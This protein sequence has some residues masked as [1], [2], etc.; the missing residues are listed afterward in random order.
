MEDD[1]R[2]FDFWDALGG[3]TDPNSL[4]EGDEDEAGVAAGGAAKVQPKLF[5]ISDATGTT[6]FTEIV[7]GDG[8]L[9]KDL[10]HSG[11]VFL[12]YGGGGKL[13]LWIGRGSSL[14]EK[15]QASKHAAE[16]IAQHGLSKGTSVERV[17]EGC[18]TVAF[19][20][21]F[22]KWELPVPKAEKKAIAAKVI[23]VAGLLAAAPRDAEGGGGEAMVD[24]GSGTVVVWVVHDFKLVA[25]DPSKY[26]Q[27]FGGDSY[28]VQYAYLKNRVEYVILYF[29]LGDKS[30][31]DERGAAALLT[32][33]KDDE[34]GGRPVQVRVTQGK[35]PAHFLQLFKGRFIVH[36]GGKASGFNS[37]VASA[38]SY[39][40]D[41]I[42]LFRVHGS[43]AL[44]TVAVQVPEQAVSLNSDDCFILVT[45]ASAFVWT[46]RGANADE[47]ATACNLASILAGDYN[48]SGGRAV[49]AVAEGAEPEEF[50]AA[51][52]GRGEYA[53]R[54]PGEPAPRDA[55]LFQASNATGAFSV[56]EVVNFEQEDLCDE[57]VFILDAFTAVFVWIGSQSNSEEKDQAMNVASQFVTAANDGRDPSMP[58]IKVSAG[59]EPL[60]FTCHFVVWDAELVERS[61]FVDP[62]AL[63]CEQLRRDKE[64]KEATNK[65][66][67]A[68]GAS[69]RQ[70]PQKAALLVEGAGAGGGS[71]AKK[72]V[73][74]SP[75]AAPASVAPSAYSNR[76]AKCN[77]F[78][79]TF[80][81]GDQAVVEA[82]VRVHSKCA[83]GGASLGGGT[84]PLAPQPVFAEASV[85]LYSAVA[86][87]YHSYEALKAG[88]PAGVTPHNK[89]EFL[90]P[91]AFKSLFE[92]D[93]VTFAALPKWKRDAKK[94][95]LGLF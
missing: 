10:L 28:L 11:D 91:K 14:N 58:V 76:C 23:D 3:F 1:E 62:Y 59:N 70:T 2:N 93:S 38:D 87:G 18:E 4:P 21:E 71:A 80:I 79:S 72:T 69:L 54:A 57:D 81:R 13:F 19:K 9:K 27:F 68:K 39:D 42:A 49:E 40:T 63:R 61:K 84:T 85:G 24:D 26:G 30:T 77:K 15:K 83:E 88:L 45:P 94:R 34:M 78:F 29:W 66:A 35:E 16:F 47:T 12:V 43:S 90:E 7:V 17:S 95:Q 44:S 92:M 50:W 73:A 67:V 89:E 74:P 82:G 6:E 64:S 37:A 46:G 20:A 86:E 41:G 60:M 33:Q 52:G 22:G 53:E 25:V 31:A 32:K 56:D 48:G 36:E 5:Q 75:G 55:R 51:L 65:A 8:I